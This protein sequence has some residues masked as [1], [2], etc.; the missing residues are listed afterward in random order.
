[1]EGGFTEI[2][3]RSALKDLGLNKAAEGINL[4]ADEFVDVDIGGKVLKNVK[5]EKHPLKLRIA[6]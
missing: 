4:N 6:I 3:Q 2:L 5:V 1:M